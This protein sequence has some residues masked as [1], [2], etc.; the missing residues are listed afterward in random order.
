V[1]SIWPSIAD[2]L[3][4]SG[5]AVELEPVEVTLA[6]HSKVAER[7]IGVETLTVGDNV[8]HKVL[9]TVTPDNKAQMLLG[10]SVLERIGK[11]SI[12]PANGRLIFG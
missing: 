3:V 4:A 7:A 9:F 12:D 6:D 5:Q 1:S 11:F 10:L 2:Q 8:L